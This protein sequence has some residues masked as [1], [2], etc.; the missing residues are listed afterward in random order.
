MRDE[1][2]FARSRWGTDEEYYKELEK[3]HKDHE[4]AHAIRYCNVTKMPIEAVYVFWPRQ[5]Y[6]EHVQLLTAIE[7]AI[8]EAS[9]E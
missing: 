6:V 4:K 3:F 2:K 7:K 1:E 9:D 5:V 8:K